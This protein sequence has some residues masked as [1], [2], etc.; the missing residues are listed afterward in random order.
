N[1]DAPSVATVDPDGLATAVNQGTAHISAAVSGIAGFASVT[2]DTAASRNAA[3]FGL[4]IRSLPTPWPTIGFGGIRLWDTATRWA[5]IEKSPGVY[6]FTT[7]DSVL[8]RAYSH[9]VTTVIYTF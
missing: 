4:H 2:V 1:S 6:D 3:L 7:L 8:A 5:Q 9:G